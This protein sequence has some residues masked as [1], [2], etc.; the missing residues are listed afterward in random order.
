MKIFSTITRAHLGVGL[1][2]SPNVSGGE[3]PEQSSWRFSESYSNLQ[4]LMSNKHAGDGEMDTVC[5]AAAPP[6]QTRRQG[7]C[8]YSIPG[9]FSHRLVWHNRH[10]LFVY[11]YSVF[12]YSRSGIY[13]YDGRSILSSQQAARAARTLGTCAGSGVAAAVDRRRPPI[14]SCLPSPSLAG[15]YKPRARESTCFTDSCFSFYSMTSANGNNWPQAARV[16]SPST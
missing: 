2:R 7:R 4:P 11:I 16:L 3:E 6:A 13:E 10:P 8:P 9:N 12:V 5:P 14:R 15:L 1:W